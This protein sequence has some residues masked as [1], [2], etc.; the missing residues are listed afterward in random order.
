MMRKTKIVATLGPSTDDLKTIAKLIKKGVNVFRLNFSHATHS[1]H[2]SLIEKIRSASSKVGIEVAILQDISGPKIRICEL[3]KPI[4]L[5]VGDILTLSKKVVDEKLKTITISYPKI[6]DSLKVGNL[7]Y[8]SDGTIRAK[9]VKKTKN[10]AQCEILVAQTLH[11]KKGINFPKTKLNINTITEKDIKDIE[12]GAKNGVDIVALSF[13]SSKKDIQTARKI[14]EPFETNPFIIAKI[15]KPEAIEN[16]DSILEESD[17]VMVARGDLGVELGVQKVPAIQKMIIEKANSLRKP[18][19]VATQ[20]LTSMINSPYPTRAEISDIANAV[21]DGSDAVMLSDE[22]TVGNYSIEAIKVLDETIKEAEKVYEYHKD[23]EVSKDESIAAAISTIAQ[24]LNPNAI[25][26]FSRSGR[27]AMSIAKFRPK[28]MIIVS[29]YDLQTLRKLQVVWGVNAK[30]ISDIYENEEEL[31]GE[32]LTE[33]LKDNL[34]S[35]KKKYVIAIGYPLDVKYATNEIKL[36]EK[37]TMQH[38]LNKIK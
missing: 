25:I 13:V 29:S 26:T 28:Q 5:Q 32:F 33:A 22:T 31:I 1:Y 37:H 14:I 23:I 17:G 2:K 18:V 12:F 30:Y 3:K 8:F 34:I 36:L 9:V 20:M 4:S 15:E 6:I 7:V 21:L 27:S 19:I 10:F 38:I 16:I 35:L 24:T 11:S